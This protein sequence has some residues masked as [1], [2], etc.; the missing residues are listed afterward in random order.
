MISIKP[1]P[2]PEVVVLFRLPK[3]VDGEFCVQFSKEEIEISMVP[4]RFAMV[5]KLLRQ[6]PSFD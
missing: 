2:I 3:F 6:G 4:F 5:M 1:Q